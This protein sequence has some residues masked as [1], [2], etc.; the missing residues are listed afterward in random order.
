ML[1]LNSDQLRAIGPATSVALDRRAARPAA[2]DQLNSLTSNQLQSL[3]SGQI[4]P[5]TTDQIQA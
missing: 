4:T 1:S 3:T 5:L 2:T